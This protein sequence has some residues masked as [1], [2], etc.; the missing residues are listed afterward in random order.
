[1]SGDGCLSPAAQAGRTSLT[2]VGLFIVPQLS[3]KQPP[4]S[5]RSS[6]GGPVSGICVG[7]TSPEQEKW[8]SHHCKVKDLLAIIFFSGSFACLAMPKIRSEP[9]A[10]PHIVNR[11]VPPVSYLWNLSVEQMSSSDEDLEFRPQRRSPPERSSSSM[12]ECSADILLYHDRTTDAVMT[13]SLL[14]TQ[15]RSQVRATD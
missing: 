8:A 10:K 11:E 9:A 3:C 6:P 5:S 13:L 12:N 4:T 15:I 14:Q 2:Q 7:R 1:M